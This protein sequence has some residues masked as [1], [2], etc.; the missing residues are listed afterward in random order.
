[1]IETKPDFY[2]EMQKNMSR[3]R[4]IMQINDVLASLP[5]K[6]CECVK[7]HDNTF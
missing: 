3:M 5:S 7:T 4:V 2:V 1:M 6:I